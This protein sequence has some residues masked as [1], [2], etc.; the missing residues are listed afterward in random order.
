MVMVTQRENT[1]VRQKQIVSAARKLIVRYG[2]E[3]VTVRRM[4]KEIGVSEG[5][6]YRHFRSKSDI[7]AFLVDDIESALIGDIERNHTGDVDSVRALENIMVDHISS[8][9]QR[10]GVSFQVIAEIVSLGDKKLN[11]QIYAVIDKYLDRIKAILEDGV[12]GGVIRP[13]VDPDAAAMLFFGMTQGLVNIWALSQ[14]NFNL[15]LK[16]KDIWDI[17]RESI[18]RH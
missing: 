17:F 16:Y 3:H 13:E 11:K 18:A 14:Y 2:S 4:A 7:L 9:E 8:I 10:K 15:Q 5:A 12:K 1:S 6:I